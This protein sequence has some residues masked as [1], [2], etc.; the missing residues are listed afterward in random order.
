MLYL[1]VIGLTTWEEG[2]HNPLTQRTEH[3]VGSISLTIPNSKKQALNGT[4]AVDDLTL[5]LLA[6][7]MGWPT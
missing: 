5:P 2:F 1:P 6:L 4:W 3:P 7:S